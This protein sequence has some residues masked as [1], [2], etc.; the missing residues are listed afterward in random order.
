MSLHLASSLQQYA[1]LTTHGVFLLTI[2]YSIR[3]IAWNP[4]GGLI[5]TGSFD[6]TLRVW[7]PEKS[8]V[9]F[10]TELRGH[11][12]SIEQVAWNPMKEAELASV[13]IDGTCKFWDVRSK[14]CV[15]TVQLGSDGLSLSWATDGSMVLIGSRKVSEGELLANFTTGITSC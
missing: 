9:K 14:G 7:N 2:N 11:T 6:K 13:S 4:T 5:A 8:Q 10:S 15:A 1:G 3:T 12:A